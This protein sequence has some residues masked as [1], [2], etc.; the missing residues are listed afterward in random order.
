MNLISAFPPILSGAASYTH[1]RVG[2]QSPNGSHRCV[3]SKRKKNETPS[4]IS[5]SE[6]PMATERE[7]EVHTRS[8]RVTSSA[9][10]LRGIGRHL[11]SPVFSLTRNLESSDIN[12]VCPLFAIYF[13][14]YQDV[15]KTIILHPL[16]DGRQ[17][18]GQI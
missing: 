4:S 5:W 17:A 8:G 9:G 14:V 7:I 1:R 18:T 11:E 6:R 16:V 13:L 10:I 15:G 12:S 3:D 2:C